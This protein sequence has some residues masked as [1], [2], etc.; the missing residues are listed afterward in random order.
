[1]EGQGTRP[2]PS[3]PPG[4]V[5]GAGWP[6]VQPLQRGPGLGGRELRW[7]PGHACHMWPQK[8]PLSG[9][10]HLTQNKGPVSPV[11]KRPSSLEH[12]LL[13]PLLSPDPPGAGRAWFFPGGGIPS[14]LGWGFLSSPPPPQQSTRLAQGSPV[15]LPSSPCPT[16]GGT[17]KVSA[18]QLTCP[19]APQS[20]GRG[21][22]EYLTMEAAYLSLNR[23][24]H[25]LV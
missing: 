17:W 18:P 22:H 4:A 12:E 15:V 10:S 14:I 9:H 21:V 2:G 8:S 24:N 19:R 20:K 6:G 11:R 5:G 16:C 23:E 25:T 1:M 13:C 3:P 7:P